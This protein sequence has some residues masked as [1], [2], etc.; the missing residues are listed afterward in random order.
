[1]N[2]PV[3]NTLSFWTP[4]LKQ[5]GGGVAPSGEQWGVPFEVATHAVSPRPNPFS[6]PQLSCTTLSRGDTHCLLFCLHLH[7]SL[8]QCGA[9][10]RATKRAKTQEDFVDKLPEIRGLYPRSSWGS[11]GKGHFG[12]RIS[13]GA[14]GDLDRVE[15]PP[16]HPTARNCP[17]WCGSSWAAAEVLDLRKK[18]FNLKSQLSKFF[19]LLKQQQQRRLLEYLIIWE[20]L[21]QY[22]PHEAATEI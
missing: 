10:T 7:S 19:F 3:W 5:H 14:G 22:W 1:M 20:S 9:I 6:L 17:V 4:F 11:K 12:W 13:E 18:Y 16:Q 21:T 2:V 8:I 15:L